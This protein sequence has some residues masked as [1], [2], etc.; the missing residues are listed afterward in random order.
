VDDREI[1]GVD[2]AD[3]Y[4]M[5]RKDDFDVVLVSYPKTMCCKV[6]R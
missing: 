6:G 2:D 4:K 3:P 1:C 5:S